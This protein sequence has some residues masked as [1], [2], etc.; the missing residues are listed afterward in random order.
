MPTGLATLAVAGVVLAV[1]E[2]GADAARRTESPSIA[3]EADAAV[4]ALE[5]WTETANPLDYVRYVQLRDETA[6]L[7]EAD[8]ELDRNSLRVVWAE[9]PIEKQQVVLNAVSQLGVPYEYLASEPGVGFDCSGLTIWAFE[10]AGVEI[11]RVSRDQIAA[12]EAT[13][14]ESAEPGDLV[15]YP[16]HISLYLGVD[17]MIHAPNSGSNVRIA[18]LPDRS[19]RF[20]DA[21]VTALDT[22][23]SLMDRALAVAK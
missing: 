16:G 19:L 15:Y 5:R 23:P 18:P 14:R 12:A 9:A 1:P 20:G 2:A 4:D 10:R 6:A 22:E 21:A 8:L 3:F 7:T 17:T 11:P 13:D